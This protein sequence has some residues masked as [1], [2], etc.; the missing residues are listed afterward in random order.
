LEF[1]VTFYDKGLCVNAVIDAIFD[2][3][4]GIFV[5]DYKTDDIS[6]PNAERRGLA[7]KSQID[8]YKRIIAKIIPSKRVEAGI[9]YLRAR[10]MI[11]I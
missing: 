10:L 5:A 8:A 1:P 3:G 4:D 6:P 9:I 2:S 7:H 11:K